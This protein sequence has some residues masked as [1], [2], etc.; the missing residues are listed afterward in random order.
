[1]ESTSTPP[2]SVADALI[3]GIF[4]DLDKFNT[5]AFGDQTVFVI[6]VK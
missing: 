6:N 3:A 4:A 5:T 2:A 1:M